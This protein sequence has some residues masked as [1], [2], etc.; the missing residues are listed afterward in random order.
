MNLLSHLTTHTDV[1]LSVDAVLC[2]LAHDH[3]LLLSRDL[4]RRALAS[5]VLTCL[6]RVI[7]RIIINTVPEQNTTAII[8]LQAISIVLD[9]DRALPCRRD[10]P[11]RCRAIGV[12]ALSTPGL[13]LTVTSAHTDPV[14]T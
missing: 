5:E 7:T 4:L 8:V 12:T 3:S 6:P 11:R 9:R 10:L 13:E 1:M 2:L 14:S